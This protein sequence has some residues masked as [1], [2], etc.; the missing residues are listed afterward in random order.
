LHLRSASDLLP[1]AVGG[2]LLLTSALSARG[3]DG[4][5][6]S[7]SISILAAILLT[8]IVWLH[9]FVLLI[10]PLGLARPRLSGAWFLLLIFWATPF[11]ENQGDGW[12]VVLAL[13]VLG[14]T[15]AISVVASGRPR[16]VRSAWGR[17]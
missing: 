12:R 11:Q 3:S 16:L 6:R 5:R 17:A 13:A 9:Y 8:P 1:W 14:T 15:G 4:D 2:T 7:F 10:V